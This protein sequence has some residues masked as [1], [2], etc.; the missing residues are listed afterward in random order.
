MQS[1]A[2]LVLLLLPA[3]PLVAGSTGNMLRSSGSLHKQRRD[4]DHHNTGHTEQH[5]L[6]GCW[7]PADLELQV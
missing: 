6:L 5:N 2:L 7:R 3:E 4:L 1:L